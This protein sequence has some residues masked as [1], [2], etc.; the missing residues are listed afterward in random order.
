LLVQSPSALGELDP[1]SLPLQ[2]KRSSC[3][4]EDCSRGGWR[5]LHAYPQQYVTRRLGSSEHIVIDGSL[6]DAAWEAVPFTDSPFLDI[7][8]PRYP[9]YVLPEKYATKV[10][11]RWDAEYLYIGAILGE[12]WVVNGSVY[13]SN[14]NLTSRLPIW[15][16]NVPYY[17]ND[18]EVFIDVSGTNYFYIE[19][20]T[21][22]N[23]A[24]FDV[25]WRAPDGG[26]G[27]VGVPCC[28]DNKCTRWCQ[29]SSWPHF[30]G[31]TF[32][33]YPNM[34]TAVARVCRGWSTEIAFP[35][36]QKDGVAGL[37]SGGPDWDRF[38]P[39]AGAQYWHVDFSRAEHP[40]FTPDAAL[41]ATLCPEI[42]KTSPTLLGADQWSCY[43]EWVWQPVGGHRYM[44]NPDT[45][46][47]LQFA[48]ADQEPVCGNIQWPA[49][50][51]LAQIYQAEVAYV[52]DAGKYSAD[53]KPLFVEKYCSVTNG[54]N[55]TDLSA[56]LD[57]YKDKYNLVIKVD[58][59]ATHCVRWWVPSRRTD[60]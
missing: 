20:E 7:A 53:L 28:S 14:A 6:D 44:H 15:A 29:N 57:M 10:K 4:G 34:K 52:Q 43:W 35:L 40:F 24:T 51:V 27:S 1:G 49:R 39:N 9:D 31:G 25:L 3:K 26:L 47:F 19:F 33:M 46:G 38:D 59:E 5:F 48:G 45:F 32:S 11:V 30:S 60:T 54:C 23:N 8:Q 12:P 36:K 58:N 13:G 41:F 37:L 22:Y 21:N 18:F 2:Q 42:M 50:Y 16:S 55:A 56:V 17:D